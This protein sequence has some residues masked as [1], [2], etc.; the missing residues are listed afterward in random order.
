MPAGPD[1][2]AVVR[3][4][5]DAFEVR[6]ETLDSYYERFWHPDA[7]IEAPDSFPVPG[8]YQGREGYRQWFEDSY[9]PY[10]DVRRELLA[11]QPVGRW[12]VALLRLSGRRQEDD[13]LLELQ[14]GT[15]YEVENGRIRRMR[16]YLGHEHALEAARADG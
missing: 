4:A 6:P 11:L 5:F 1:D 3:R 10:A 9:A 12:V 16:V 15:A 13:V 8:R 7:V 2:I 14:I